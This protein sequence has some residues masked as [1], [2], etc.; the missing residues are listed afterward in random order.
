MHKTNNE[1][2]LLPC[3][4]CGP[5]ADAKPMLLSNKKKHF[6]KIH[7]TVQ[8]TNCGCEPDYCVETEWDAVTTWNKRDSLDK[9]Q[10]FMNGYNHAKEDI[11]TMIGMLVIKEP[12]CLK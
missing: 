12:P 5:Y 1:Y 2:T 11:K 10:D 7:H 3:P 9:N 6:D 4:F 8:C